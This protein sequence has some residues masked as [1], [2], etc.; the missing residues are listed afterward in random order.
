MRILGAL[1]P[2]VHDWFLANNVP[3]Y[4]KAAFYGF[5]SSVSLPIGA[6]LGVAMSPIPIAPCAMIMA[7]GAGALI[8]AVSTEMYA[9]ALRQVELDGG[10]EALWE[11]TLSMTCALLGAA[12]FTALNLRLEDCTRI[13]DSTKEERAPLVKSSP[14]ERAMR[15]SKTEGAGTRSPMPQE[16][17]PTSFRMPETKRHDSAYQAAFAMWLGIGLDGIPESVLIGFITNELA[18]TVAFI[19]AI[20][21]AN[22]PEA[23]SSASML[24]TRGMET[25]KIIVMW[26]SLCVVCTVLSGLSSFLL[27]AEL[28]KVG[29][30]GPP[31][32]YRLFGAAIEGLAGGAMLAMVCGTMLPEA[33]HI[34]GTWCGMAAVS[35]FI[36]SCTVKVICGRMPGGNVQAD[37]GGAGIVE[38]EVLPVVE[39]ITAPVVGEQVADLATNTT[40]KAIEALFLAVNRSLA[41]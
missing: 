37:A 28:H 4:Y 26:S 10:E 25:W 30:H 38:D 19:V 7:F 16:V 12:G 24:K 17:E 5:L 34:G 29:G 21:V 31:V 6:V 14:E 15:R 35:G 2:V 33:F 13:V 8:F 27:P 36:F 40:A 23:F 9:E 11:I 18:M 22:F 32:E 41:H 39:N 3:L 1:I 20:F